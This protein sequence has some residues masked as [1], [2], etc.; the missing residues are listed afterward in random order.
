MKRK[1]QRAYASFLLRKPSTTLLFIF[2]WPELGGHM[3]IFSVKEGGK[4]SLHTL[5]G[6]MPKPDIGDYNVTVLQG[7]CGY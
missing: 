4:G 1:G 2:L 5:G 7:G 6:H 3:A